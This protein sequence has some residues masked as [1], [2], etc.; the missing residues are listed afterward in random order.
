MVGGHLAASGG[1]VF[2]YTPAGFHCCMK[3]VL[4]LLTLQS[5]VQGTRRYVCRI[6]ELFSITFGA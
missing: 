4:H 3:G 5:D 2:S 1:G 6:V